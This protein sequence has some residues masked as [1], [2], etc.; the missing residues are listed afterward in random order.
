MLDGEGSSGVN[1]R[2]KAG[3]APSLAF[4]LVFAASLF[5]GWGCSH[6]E[7]ETGLGESSQAI[8]DGTDASAQ[9]TPGG[10]VKLKAIGVRYVNGQPT[11]GSENGS[12]VLLTNEWVLTAAH[13]VDGAAS[14]PSTISVDLDGET[15]KAAEV[16]IHPLYRRSTQPN[17]PN[18]ATQ[19]LT[20]DNVD[21]ALVKLVSPI[22]T[23]TTYRRVISRF[24]D[25]DLEGG[26]VDCFGYGRFAR[27]NDAPS[28]NLRTARLLVGDQTGPFSSTFD[29]LQNDLGQI[30]DSGDSGGACLFNDEVVGIVRAKT[31]RQ[32]TSNNDCPLEQST[33]QNATCR[34][35]PQSNI[36][37]CDHVVEHIQAAASFRGFIRA[38][39]RLPA[40]GLAGSSDSVTIGVDPVTKNFEITVSIGGV[41]TVLPTTLPDPTGGAGLAQVEVTDF[42][43]D[44]VPDLVFLFQTVDAAGKRI[45]MGFTILAPTDPAGWVNAIANAIVPNGTSMVVAD[46]A[47]F[48]MTED[49]DEDG[50]D[51]L[52]VVNQDGT[53]D[54]FF[55]TGASFA[56]T[57]ARTFRVDATGDGTMDRVFLSKSAGTSKVHWS[58]N[59]EQP[60]RGND[61]TVNF[62]A[63]FD[64]EA[65]DFNGDGAADIGILSNGQQ[66]YIQATRFGGYSGAALPTDNKY[67]GITVSD[68]DGNG[69]DDLEAARANGEVRAFMGSGSGLGTTP[70]ILH[71][72]PTADGTDGKFMVLGGRNLSTVVDAKVDVFISEPVTAAGAP[73]GK[74][75]IIQVFDGDSDL[76]ND[77]VSEDQL[78]R[79]CLRLIPDPNPGIS[80]EMGE[81]CRLEEGDDGAACDNFTKVQDEGETPFLDNGWWTFFNTGNGDAH[82][83]R[84]RLT[85]SS[86]RW[87]RLEVSLAEGCFS[88]PAAGIGGSNG[89]KL[90]TNGQMR[91][92]HALTLIAKD[93]FGAFSAP[94][95]APAADTKYDGTLNV[96]FFV[97]N[98]SSRFF[99]PGA[100]DPSGITLSQ[101][102]ADDTDLGGAAD[103][104]TPDIYFELFAGDS[105]SGTALHLDRVQGT[106][107][108]PGPVT[109]VEDPSGNFTGATP[110]FE[111]HELTDPLVVGSYTWHWGN[112]R[113][114]NAI[115]LL[116]AT[117]SPV[118]HEF[119]AG[120]WLSSS[121]A[122]PPS[123]WLSDSSVAAL[124]P[125]VIGGGA[126]GQ[127]IDVIS[128]PQATRLLSGSD[129]T[130]SSIL[131]R[132]ALAL[133]LNVKRA[134]QA[135]EPLDAATV[136]SSSYTVARLLDEADT[137]IRRGATD[138]PAAQLARLLGAANDG[139]VTYLSPETITFSSADTDGDGLAD[140]LDNCPAVSN[141]DQLD[142]NFDG[143][144][145]ACEPKPQVSCV[146][147]VQ[148]GFLAVFGY[149]N[150]GLDARVMPGA[151][152]QVTGGTVQGTQPVL[153][154]SGS[155]EQALMVKS[156]GA[157]VSWSVFGKSVTATASA[158]RCPNTPGTLACT[159]QVGGLR[160]CT[161]LSSCQTAAAFGLYATESL[162]LGDRV[163][164]L[165]SSGAAAPVLDL[166]A[167]VTIGTD[168]LV[169]AVVA[170][171]NVILGDRTSVAGS[172]TTSGTVTRGSGV[173]ISGL[174]T[175]HA[176]IGAPTLADF[177]FPIAVGSTDVVLQ[178]DTKASRSA[179]AYGKLDVRSR[180]TLTLGGGTYF[181]SSL[182]LEPQA[183]IASDGTG[184]VTLHVQGDVVLRGT[185]FAGVT[186]IHHGTGQVQLES[187]NDLTVI[188]PAGTIVLSTQGSPLKGAFFARHIQALPGVVVQTHRLA[189]TFL[190]ATP[191]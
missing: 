61:T 118:F 188:S 140:T 125:I 77:R 91:T 180:A 50:D 60:S 183:I 104:A 13:V 169:G 146:T 181:I 42:N 1:A 39:L 167:G 144:G 129:A 92:A 86:P 56:S 4:A 190:G 161:G 69:F 133:K 102:D 152:N 52:V 44:A 10:F 149:V 115:H 16:I 78:A 126:L 186:I 54:T 84:A 12:G 187:A 136:L 94:T 175:D 139:R 66:F 26:F 112:V 128:T 173:T 27:G 41:V 89:F 122:K 14:T 15:R 184:P 103:G 99:V 107:P 95:S 134:A 121:L 120:D 75:L 154:Q 132:E 48:L 162:V 20:L 21:M 58:A 63:P 43:G 71:G 168:A 5:G 62:V 53:V 110:D 176:T 148:G 9:V 106:G 153:F 155:H 3:P 138:A 114:E 113:T 81:G 64:A 22:N 34:L 83:D 87:Y 72:L 145:D 108:D 179:G 40:D 38:A 163:K 28:T 30:P 119:V 6:S 191:I 142:A 172:L 65:G 171:G 67:T 18:S 80:D 85:A 88:P 189:P 157:P 46:S 45:S 100:P 170:G 147:P 31:L 47:S 185:L 74:P 116:P 70:T 101:A 49:G 137:A 182:S 8:I 105:A 143:T 17:T 150:A 178:P 55:D 97:G 32:C 2:C 165:D 59:T 174:V 98:G 76:L 25:A 37:F 131:L 96:N 29:V 33:G 11:I 151:F 111:V 36:S 109:R 117:G 160:C 159:E 123:S 35:D 135:G 57:P 127:R 7:H 82:D 19:P 51:D 124:L 156:T 79:T 141:A 24:T 93:S 23:A 68:V 90:R 164:V 166:G 73:T 130:L 177:A 158:P